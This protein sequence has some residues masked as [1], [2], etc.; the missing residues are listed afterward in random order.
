MQRKG[1]VT[2]FRLGQVVAKPG[3]LDA[4]PRGELLAAL[5]R[6]QHCDWGEVPATDW[7]ANDLALT[8]G[9]RI[10]SAYESETK[11]KFWI[12]TEADRSATTLLL[13]EEY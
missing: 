3:I 5:K 8:H 7:A 2:Q 4:V 11:T 1:I 12:I 10:I 6:H 9:G 13:P